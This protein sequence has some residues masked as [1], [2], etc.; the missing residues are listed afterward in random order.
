MGKERMKRGSSD[1]PVSGGVTD[2]ANL[3]PSMFRVDP[4]TLRL[5]TLASIVTQKS[6]TMDEGSGAV[7]VNAVTTVVMAT[8]SD[9]I[10]AWMWNDSDEVQ[11]LGYGTAAVLNQG[12]RLNPNGG[13]LV[14]PNFTGAINAICA[15]G[16]KVLTFIEM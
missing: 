9:R 2:D 10:K 14:E 3:Y 6:A 8:N 11:Y 4:T 5:K 1:M 13:S 15:S 7:S 12:P 16:G